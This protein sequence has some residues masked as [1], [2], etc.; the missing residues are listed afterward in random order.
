MGHRRPSSLEGVE[1]STP[2]TVALAIVDGEFGVKQL[3]LN[4][5]GDL[6]A[7]KIADKVQMVLDPKLDQMF[8]KYRP[9]RVTITTDTGDS[10]TKEIIE[11]HGEPRSDFAVAGVT[12]KFF[13]LTS[14]KF[15]NDRANKIYEI[16]DNLENFSSLETLVNLLRGKPNESCSSHVSTEKVARR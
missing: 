2:F 3:S 15:G 8:P 7:L 10:F 5:L 14:E 1:Y 13:Q 4:R 16:V 12:E 6:K 9:A 11:V